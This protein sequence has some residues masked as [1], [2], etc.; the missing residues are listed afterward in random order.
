MAFMQMS[1]TFTYVFIFI[2][3]T[4]S[5]LV[6]VL[7]S[8]LADEYRAQSETV[9]K[10]FSVLSDLILISYHT[11]KNHNVLHVIELLRVKESR[12]LLSLRSQ[13]T[14]QICRPEPAFIP[15]EHLLETELIS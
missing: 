13:V 15:R 10:L 5:I 9:G 6:N 7:Q 14:V 12:E 1:N 11:Y 3:M 2:Y 4:I 8:F